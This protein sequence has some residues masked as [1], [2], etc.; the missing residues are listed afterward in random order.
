[1]LGLSLDQQ[2]WMVKAVEAVLDQTE[3]T[4]RKNPRAEIFVV[5]SRQAQIVRV[6]AVQVQVIVQ[7]T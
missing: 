7:D 5:P 1:M 2:K 3:R 4:Q 6:V